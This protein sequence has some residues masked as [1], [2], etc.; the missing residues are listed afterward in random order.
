MKKFFT[1]LFFVLL[2]GC[3]YTTNDPDA[4]FVTKDSIIITYDSLEPAITDDTEV[5][6]ISK[7]PALDTSTVIVELRKNLSIIKEQ[8]KQLDS[9]LEK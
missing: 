4:T 8:Q 1:L 2:S 9:L 7:S 3:Y 5:I 6:I